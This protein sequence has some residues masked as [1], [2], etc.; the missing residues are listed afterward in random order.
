MSQHLIKEVQMLK[1][2]LR[3]AIQRVNKLEETV[4][5]LMHQDELDEPEMDSAEDYQQYLQGKRA[6]AA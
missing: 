4:T 6:A 3:E 1:L 2:E 5:K